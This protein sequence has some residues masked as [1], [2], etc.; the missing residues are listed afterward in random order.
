MVHFEFKSNNNHFITS[1]EG[2][3]LQVY[4]FTKHTIHPSSIRKIHW[5]PIATIHP[6][7]PTDHK[8]AYDGVTFP[9]DR[10]TIEG[11]E[12]LTML[13]RHLNG[14]QLLVSSEGYCFQEVSDLGM[15][16]NFGVHYLRLN[17][18]FNWQRYTIDRALTTNVNEYWRR[19]DLEYNDPISTPP[20]GGGVPSKENYSKLQRLVK[21][22][23]EEL[24]KLKKEKGENE[25]ECKKNYSKLMKE[26]NE[27]LAKLKAI[28]QTKKESWAIL[29]STKFLPE[30]SDNNLPTRKRY[31]P[32]NFYCLPIGEFPHVSNSPK[33]LDNMFVW[34]SYSVKL[35]DEG[36]NWPSPP[37]VMVFNGTG[38]EFDRNNWWYVKTTHPEG[39]L[40]MMVYYDGNRSHISVG[41][42]KY[43]IPLPFPRGVT[44]FFSQRYNMSIYILFKY[45]M[46][47]GFTYRS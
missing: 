5:N 40:T 11:R 26:K 6:E 42:G 18:L 21:E 7:N 47:L 30:G 32:E 29:S 39:G 19:L 4:E 14:L 24:A 43:V 3:T 37:H 36:I 44:E 41:S 23:D 38:Q 25:V 1:P 10:G 46:R 33:L 20:G 16:S 15:Y 12:A 27:E 13:A 2:T 28:E 22:K 17:D 35:V 31:P 9:E 8:Q 34:D 45:G